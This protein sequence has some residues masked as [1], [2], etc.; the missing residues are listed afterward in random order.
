MSPPA[1]L[2][3]GCG[4][5]CAAVLRLRSV[6]L[7]MCGCHPSTSWSVQ[8][9]GT[10]CQAASRHPASL[11]PSAGSLVRVPAVT[12]WHVLSGVTGWPTRLDSRC[13]T[14]NG[15]PDVLANGLFWR[16]F[17]RPRPTARGA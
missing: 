12:A 16:H 14:A 7:P 4:S 17:A 9:R 3:S 15:P 10:G 2:Y 11:L 8:T 6:P 1:P 13:G 5:S